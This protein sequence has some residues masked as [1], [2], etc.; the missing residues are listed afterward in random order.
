MM[1]M[2]HSLSTVNKIFIKCVY[3]TMSHYSLE[4]FTVFFVFFL[5]SPI[6]KQAYTLAHNS[7]SQLNF[8]SSGQLAILEDILESHNCKDATDTQ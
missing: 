7:S 4:S 8:A 6:L 2:A 3:Q 5:S 1:F